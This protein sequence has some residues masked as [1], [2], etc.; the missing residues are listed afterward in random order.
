MSERGRGHPGA[1]AGGAAGQVVMYGK[2]HLIPG[3]AGYMP[4]VYGGLRGVVPGK[5]GY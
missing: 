5:Q 3:Y 4:D 1:S 2:C